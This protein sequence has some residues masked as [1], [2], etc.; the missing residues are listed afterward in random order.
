[1]DLTAID[2]GGEFYDPATVTDKPR[3]DM[4]FRPCHNL[5]ERA[6]AGYLAPGDY[7]AFW[8]QQHILS[9]VPAH[10]AVTGVACF[11]WY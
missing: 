9:N 5:D 3:F 1:L 4:M 11:S 6:I 2:N 7:A 8:L 10:A